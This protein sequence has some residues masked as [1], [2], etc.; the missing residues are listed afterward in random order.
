M[1]S[2]TNARGVQGA[3]AAEIVAGMERFAIFNARVVNEGEEFLGGVAVDER[4]MISRVF[5]GAEAPAGYK[6][7]DACGAYLFP[8][9]IDEHVHFR[10]PGLTAKGD[11]ASESAA[12]V[13]GGVTSYMDMPNTKPATLSNAA[14]EERQ[15][16]AEGRSY[17]NYAFH[18]GASSKNI[19]EIR[20]ADPTV[21]PA[22]KVFMGASTGNMQVSQ[23]FLSPI[24][25]SSR[26]PILT[27][28]ECDEILN[29][30]LKAAKEVHGDAIPFREHAAIRS[31]K[32]CLESVR[33]A[34]ELA[35][36]HDARLHI[37]HISS[38]LETDYLRELQ[39]QGN[40]AVSA[41]TCPHYFTF[42][43]DAYEHFGGKIKCNPSVKYAAD[44][45]A[46]I[47]GLADGIFLTIGT[48]HAPHLLEEKMTNYTAC[49]SG[50]PSVQYGLVASMELVAS[51]V[52]SAADVARLYAHAPAALF[53]VE[54]RGFIREGY[55]ADLVL[56]ER[57]PI[58]V[59][60][61]RAIGKC[62]WS[63]YEELTFRHRVLSTYVNG[64]LAW[65]GHSIVG[66]PSGEGLRFE[67]FRL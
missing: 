41:E 21:V 1:G 5:H 59:Q 38:A 64:V 28:C 7:V 57:L 52:L 40:V 22:I 11:V 60:G 25:A 15:R 19:E 61:D 44:R 9:A 55:H 45:D 24:F 67:R 16:A 66:K 46:I 32:A 37:M 14:I 51:G 54:R 6:P 26:L 50:I 2:A 20:S 63:P 29:S 39:A 8:G 18:L 56:L 47:K 33:Q 3:N 49:P 27:H 42:S 31:D 12:A 65:D 35:T 13:A 34:V 43:A 53:G 23:S 62:R 10:E 17:A 36:R 48:D 30:N 58:A 4:G